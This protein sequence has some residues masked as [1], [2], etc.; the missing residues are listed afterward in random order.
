[1]SSPDLQFLRERL[2]RQI[3]SA[4]Q[5]NPEL[6]SLPAQNLSTAGN[7]PDIDY[8][9]LSRGSWAPRL[10]LTR[11]QALATRATASGDA[12]L[13]AQ[14]FA[15]LG[16]WIEYDPL[17][18]NWWHNQIGTPRLLAQSMILLG[19]RLPPDLLASSRKILSRAGEFVLS[20]D[21]LTRKPTHWTGANRLWI[22]ANQLL[23]G[24]L[25]D[26][27]AL[28]AH[29]IN[30]ALKEIRVATRDEE[31]VQI[32]GSF[33]QHGPLLY[34]G[35]YGL[36]FID[37]CASLLDGIQGTAWEPDRHYHRLLADF[38]LDGTRWMLRG[39]DINHGCLDRE[40]TRPR[41][42]SASLA[43]VTAFL[44]GSDVERRNE[45]RDLTESLHAATAPG[46][47]EGNRM[48]YRSDFMVQQSRAA[49]LSVRMHSTRTV[50]AEVCNGEGKRS[51]HV[52]D[53][54]TCLLRTGAE[55]LD[56][57]PVWDWQRLP[58]I[59]CEQTPCPEPPETV[60]RRG[61]RPTTGGVSDGRHGACLQHLDDVGI[62]ARQS[63]FFGPDDMVCLGTDIRGGSGGPVVTTLDQSL[64]QGPVETDTTSAPLAPGVHALK[65]TRWLRHGSWGFVFPKPADVV[66][67]LG[68][69]T[70]AWSLIGSGSPDP[71]TK[72]VFLAYLN[73]GATPSGSSYAYQV[74]PDAAPAALQLAATRPA[75]EI[76]SQTAAC[77]AV[78]RPATHLLQ[79]AFFA[80]ATLAWADGWTLHV[81]RACAVMLS[82]TDAADTW[83]IDVA[84]VEQAGGVMHIELHSPDGKLRTCTVS[85]PEGDHLGR[86]T[87]VTG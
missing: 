60:A 27:E 51:H 11:T 16:W 1:M 29:A 28:V 54:L 42:T 78:W 43:R 7:W 77:H 81:D 65:Q 15:A 31:G 32:D 10:H 12:L 44:A 23:A 63:W 46:Q 61:G 48:F 76:V 62:E 17:S 59:T 5:E 57:F 8:T 35:G 6:S 21:A 84:D 79:A 82:R 37:E 13:I 22:S 56:I 14:T 68:P 40:M 36:A 24:A 80:P 72:E 66:V 20:E 70:G 19:D 75:F 41:K 26:D 25:L 87:R 3:V 52:A 4:S 34:N 83:Q 58:G 55:Y 30:E 49:A 18:P 73:H 50:R 38:I 71:V 47:L 85:L 2:R 67:E 69:K 86:T 64:R 33:H 39:Q 53:G 45:L 74:L 9:D